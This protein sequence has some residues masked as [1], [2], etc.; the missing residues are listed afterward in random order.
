[1]S[2]ILDLVIIAIILIGAFNGW[3]YGGISAAVKLIGTILVF[4]LAYYLKNPISVL[5]YENLPFFKF[6][7]MF[8]GITS[9][10][11]LLYEAI[12]FIIAM[13]LLTI[14][15][16]IIIKV[17]KVLDKI[18]NMTIILALPSKLLGL[19]LGALQYYVIIYFVIFILLQI[20]FTS[21]YMNESTAAKMIAD[22]TPGLSMVTK[23][24]YTT[25]NEVYDICVRYD[26]STDKQKGDYEALDT[27]M[28]HEII[29]SKSVQ[30][31]KDKNKLEIDNL[32][33]LITKYNK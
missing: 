21:K 28:K 4:I 18:V 32:D 6:G 3:K 26:N 5:L 12:A 24:L 29:T 16:A 19:I 10:N 13:S 7:G 15:I 1:M 31:L 9:L 30:K 2:A 22:K 20:P 27:L 23:E 8:K 17:T 11:I 25:Y 14:A 33:E